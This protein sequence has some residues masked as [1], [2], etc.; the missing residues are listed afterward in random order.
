MHRCACICASSLCGD[1]GV[2]AAYHSES[3]KNNLHKT[4][5]KQNKPYHTTLYCITHKYKFTEDFFYRNLIFFFGK[6]NG[7][8]IFP[9]QPFTIKTDIIRHYLWGKLQNTEIITGNEIAYI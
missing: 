9:A 1:T 7:I 2:C 3:S 8:L 5:N 6:D 4:T